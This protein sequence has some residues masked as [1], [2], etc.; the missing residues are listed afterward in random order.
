MKF[1]YKKNS[2]IQK[3]K[4]MKNTIKYISPWNLDM[5]SVSYLKEIIKENGKIPINFF[6]WE[7]QKKFV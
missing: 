2:F 5:T 4:K 7:S 1:F 6:N 3:I